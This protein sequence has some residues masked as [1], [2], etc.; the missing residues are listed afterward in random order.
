MSSG[1]SISEAEQADNTEAVLNLRFGMKINFEYML[2]MFGLDKTIHT[3][4]IQINNMTL[5][6]NVILDKSSSDGKFNAHASL[7]TSTLD[8]LIIEFGEHKALWPLQTIYHL[9]FPNAWSQAL[10]V[11]SL[12]S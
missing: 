8:G 7:K 10:L 3:G 4:Y 1:A 12:I 2:S 9:L 6:A 11:N 5:P